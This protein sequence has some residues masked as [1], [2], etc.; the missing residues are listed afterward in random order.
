MDPSILIN[1]MSP[2]LVLGVSGVHFYFI[3]ERH[4][5]QQ[6]VHTLIK[7][8]V[9][10]RLIWVY[11]VCLSPIYWTL[12]T[13]GLRLIYVTLNPGRFGCLPS[14]VCCFPST[15]TRSSCVTFG[16]VKSSQAWKYKWV[17]T[18]QNQ[19][20]DCAPSEDSD[21]PGHPPSLIRVFAVCWMG[22]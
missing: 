4:S 8:H 22:S 9:L 18:W 2:F 15:P 19:Q 14:N 7:R 12:G 13:S 3:S 5:C 10:R 17:T 1:W 20:N 11:T 21:R 16:R 6:T